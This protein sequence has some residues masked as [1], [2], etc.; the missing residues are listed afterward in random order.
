MQ[1]LWRVSWSEGNEQEMYQFLYISHSSVLTPK[2]ASD[3]ALVH[4]YVQPVQMVE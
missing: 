1:D 3:L 2:I 4:T